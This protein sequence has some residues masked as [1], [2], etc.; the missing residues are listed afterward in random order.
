[1]TIVVATYQRR[2]SVERLVANLGEQIAAD[3]ELRDGLDMVVVVDGSTD[4]TVELL[5]A[6]EF[7]VPLKTS[8]QRN[9]GRAAARNVGLSLAQGALVL[10]LD[11]DVV[12]GPMLIRRHREAH[13]QHAETIVMGPHLEAD[14]A[15]SFAPNQAW[16]DAIYAEMAAT[17][18]V[19]ASQFSTANTSG[20]TEV[21]LALGGFD[22]GF[23]DWGGEDTDLAQR[24]LKAGYEI[25]FDPA[26]RAL[27]HEHLTI[28]QFCANNV[29]AGRTLPRIVALH[30]ELL[31]ELIPRVPVVPSRRRLRRMA[32]AAHRSFPIRSPLFY[33][34]LASMASALA[35]LERTVTAARSQRALYVAMVAST[36][37]GIAEADP[38]GAL[39]ARKLGAER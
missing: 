2:Q 14:D 26:I 27:H 1:M 35:P 6:V 30:P 21:F 39:L 7:P 34:C 9:R 5:D 11:D 29:S 13:E 38:S 12:P 31:D 23:T 24:G 15:E 19:K 17:G 18:T 3:L 37:S 33:R 25:L 8:F 20:P 28:K 32:A 36:L 10:F 4:G 22:E 16:V